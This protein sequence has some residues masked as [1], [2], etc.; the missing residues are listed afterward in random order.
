MPD[1]QIPIKVDVKISSA[2]AAKAFNKFMDTIKAPFAW[3]A[4]NREPKVQAK[5]DAKAAIIR[6][7]AAGPLA[8][9]LGIE[10]EEAVELI[11]RGEQRD[12]YNQIRQQRN[13]EA[14]AQGAANMLP[15]SV[16]DQPVDEDWTAEFFEQCKNVN[17]EK[18]QSLWSKILAGEVAEPGS[19]SRRTLSFVRSLS[20]IEADLFT[21]FCSFL[22]SDHLHKYV[23]IR[24]PKFSLE[25]H[26]IGPSD[27]A[28]LNSLGLIDLNSE[29]IKIKLHKSISVLF[30]H[31]QA[32]YVTS[33]TSPNAHY[34]PAAIVLPKLGQELVPIAGGVRN[35]EYRTAIVTDMQQTKIFEVSEKP[36][37]FI[38][39]PTW[40]Y[41]C[42]QDGEG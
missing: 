27:L 42:D 2:D 24:S 40:Q 31:G 12:L 9:E 5:A 15:P 33:K 41:V 11:F 28:E 6:A 13:L 19:F 35:E 25:S 7:K 17:N 14:I 37:E 21:R 29:R 18:M 39:E 4:K 38:K 36:P 16:N 8:A 1:E 10:K 26:G 23:H 32:H 34:I 22:W 30:Y 3:W 20:Q